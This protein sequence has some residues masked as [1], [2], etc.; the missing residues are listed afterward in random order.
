MAG[1]FENWTDTKTGELIESCTIITKD[2]YEKISHIHNRMPVVLPEEL[3]REWLSCK[4]IDFP[5]TAMNQLD[6]YP[7][8]NDVGSPKNDYYFK[9]VN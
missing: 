8:S 9:H 1:L 7:I 4:L 3:Y 5:A 6:Y 2:S